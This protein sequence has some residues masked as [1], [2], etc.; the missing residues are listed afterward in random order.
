MKDSKNGSVKLALLMGALGV[1]FGDIGTSPLYAVRESLHAIHQGVSPTIIYGIM[2][3]IT[4][5]LIIVISLKYLAF[6][7]RADNQ[8]EGGILALLA[9]AS[10]RKV[11]R[12]GSPFR[13]I[14]PIGVFGAALLYGDGIITPAISVL[15]AVEGL[16][17]VTPNFSP[18][19]IPLTLGILT[20]LFFVQKQGTQK[21]G[22]VFGPI[23]LIWFASIGILGLV[24]IWETPEILNS[25]NPYYAF[26]FI[27]ESPTIAF[28]VLGSVFLVVTGGEALY[29][30][31]GHFGRKPIRRAWILFVFPGLLLN[32]LGQGAL[33]IRN[34]EAIENPFFKMCPEQLLIPLVALSTIAT[35]IAS[36]ALISGVFSLTRQAMQLGYLPRIQ[37]VHTSKDEIGQIYIPF[38]NWTLYI[39]VVLLVIGFQTSSNMAAAYGIAVTGT[40]VITT[41]LAYFV[42]R[43]RWG[44]SQPLALLVATPLLIIDLTFFS[45]N[46]LK[47]T[48]GGWFPLMVGLIFYT[49]MSTWRRGRYL[50]AQRMRELSQPID[51]FIAHV[52]KEKP[53]TVPGIALFMTSDPEGAPPALVHNLRHNR[54]L[55]KDI[56]LVTIQTKDVPNISP[57]ER[58]RVDHLTDN[59]YRIVAFY[60]FM[61]APTI[62]EILNGAASK[63]YDFAIN[64]I[65]FFLG[66]ETILP[67]AR[68]GMPIWR[69]SIFAFMSRNAERATAF[70]KIPP[71][72]VIEVGLQI[73]I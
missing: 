21:I 50:L 68:P 64:E 70:F 36:Q 8:G 9:L 2:S 3:L 16:K 51:V 17:I 29:T 30:D 12:S 47:L 58:V 22:A 23:M 43:K 41:L 56:V 44:W 1:V 42:T 57:D 73:E 33:L 38:I 61:E 32:Y 7:M 72:Q 26:N 46:L 54:I 37:I 52:K 19:I 39:L 15:S 71:D 5:S 40:M 45:S 60:G 49:F 28:V 35:V 65:T 24:S 48:D 69:E 10:P 6:V 55:H 18:Y 67:S 27:I 53:Q 34:P 13:F 62:Q 4:W 20:V 25:M 31:M 14:V 66:R 59:L 11:Y 63:G